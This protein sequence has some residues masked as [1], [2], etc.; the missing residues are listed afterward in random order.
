MLPTPLAAESAP[1]RGSG[2]G[3]NEG[4]VEE[5]V[6]A[7]ATGENVVQESPER[8]YV[9]H[10]RR[11]PA[12]LPGKSIREQP[13]VGPHGA[14]MGS[15]FEANRLVFAGAF[16]DDQSGGIAFVRAPDHAAAEAIMNEDPAIRSGLFE[17]EIRPWVA[18]YRRDRTVN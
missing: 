16:L 5:R 13:L 1:S 15:L 18:L 6:E 8:L 2:I 10:Y 12:W 17:G 7:G 4:R 9:I 3:A 14:Y 11:G